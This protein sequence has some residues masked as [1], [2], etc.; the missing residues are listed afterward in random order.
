MTFLPHGSALDPRLLAH[1][2]M[3]DDC[4]CGTSSKTFDSV[5]EYYGKILH[6][7]DDLKTNAC[8]TSCG[9]GV[10]KR[11]KKVIAE[12]HEEVVSK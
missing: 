1:G 12:C 11:V 2:T 7:T 3:A 8:T 5:K 9:A 6:G 10:P 4:C